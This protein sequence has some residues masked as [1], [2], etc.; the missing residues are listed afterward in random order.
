LALKDR[1]QSRGSQSLRDTWPRWVEEER[2]VIG[3]VAALQGRIQIRISR[4]EK[5][6]LV[7]P[8]KKNL[9]AKCGGVAKEEKGSLAQIT[10]L[11]GGLKM[12]GAPVGLNIAALG[13]GVIV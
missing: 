3:K 2:D 8:S 9:R 5:G 10:F 6:M 13:E 11:T 1:R 12:I 4:K 7:Y